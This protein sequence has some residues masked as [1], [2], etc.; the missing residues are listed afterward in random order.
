M[1]NRNLQSLNVNG[2]ITATS[3]KQSDTFVSKD[4]RKSLYFTASNDEDSQK[5]KA[6][7]MQEYTPNDPEGKPYFI[8]QSASKISLYNAQK[9][10]YAE[11]SGI[12]E[13]S[14]NFHTDG[15][16]VRLAIVKGWN[17]QFKK[18][19]F[20]LTAILVNDE[21]HIQEVEEI[22]PFADE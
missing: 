16:V 13:E 12:A 15:N 7:G 3:D 19:F 21:T 17:D 14:R 4:P 10:K 22:N 2:I 6:F 18:S 9:E 20:R 5:L 1:S 11:V 8:I